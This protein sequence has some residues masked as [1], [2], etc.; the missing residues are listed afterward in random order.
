MEVYMRFFGTSAIALCVALAAPASGH[1]QPYGPGMMGYG[2]HHGMMGYGMHHGMMGRFG[3][4]GMMSA[5]NIAC[6]PDGSVPNFGFARGAGALNLSVEDV[7]NYAETAIAWNGNPNLKVGAVRER[8]ADTVT[9]DIVTKDNS[10]V[11][12]L[13]FDR[14]TGFSC[15]VLAAE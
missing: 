3:M 11:E 13:A 9:A 12:R 2:M 10:L 15:F 4:G 14:H 5:R 7:K 1:A 6:N 8:D